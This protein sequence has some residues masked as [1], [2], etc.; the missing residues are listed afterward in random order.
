MEIEG[1]DMNEYL[2]HGDHGNESLVLILQS[3]VSLFEIFT[4]AT[5]LDATL[6][7]VYEMAYKITHHSLQTQHNNEV[8]TTRIHHLGLLAV[9][10]LL[11]NFPIPQQKGYERWDNMLLA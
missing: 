6:I 11:H 10:N 2:Q 7:M 9:S 4:R 1:I 5:I 8:V 3:P